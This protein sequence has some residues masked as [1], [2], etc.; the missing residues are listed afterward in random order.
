MEEA[1]IPQKSSLSFDDDEG[2]GIILSYNWSAEHKPSSMFIYWGN[3]KY[4]EQLWNFTTEKFGKE[5]VEN[6]WKNI[7]KLDKN[8]KLNL[9]SLC[10]NIE[11]T[12]LEIK[13]NLE[14]Q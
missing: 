10:D 2:V 8:K 11:S 6:Y 13:K 7:L 3:E 12:F 4:R 1:W 14:T 5:K 9:D